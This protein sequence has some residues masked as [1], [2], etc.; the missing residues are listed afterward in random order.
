RSGAV[1]GIRAG[2]RFA[3]LRASPPY[4]TDRFESRSS[5]ERGEKWQV[6]PGRQG[7][8]I[9]FGAPYDS[10]LHVPEVQ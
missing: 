1:R 7:P 6:E 2:R 4:G 5:A 3:E 8:A 10:C 9:L